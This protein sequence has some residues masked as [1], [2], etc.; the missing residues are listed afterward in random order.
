MGL[1]FS[2]LHFDWLLNMHWLSKY[3]ATARGPDS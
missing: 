1:A 3:A 2:H